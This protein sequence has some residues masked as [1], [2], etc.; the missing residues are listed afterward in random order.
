LDEEGLNMAV[1]VSQAKAIPEKAAIEVQ[2]AVH[3]LPKSERSIFSLIE[4][5]RFAVMASPFCLAAIMIF[6][7]MFAGQRVHAVIDYLTGISQR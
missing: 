7:N 2:G 6:L 5:N 1:S 3:P 4:R